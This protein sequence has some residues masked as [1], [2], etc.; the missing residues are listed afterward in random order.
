MLNQHSIAGDPSPLKMSPLDKGFG[1]T[2]LDEIAALRSKHVIS[3]FGVL[4]KKWKTQ[5]DKSPYHILSFFLCKWVP[6]WPGLN[7]LMSLL[8]HT[9]EKPLKT[10][11]SLKSLQ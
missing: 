2:V 10:T 7:L 6:E 11:S 9:K 5:P 1:M 3:A 4:E 8:E